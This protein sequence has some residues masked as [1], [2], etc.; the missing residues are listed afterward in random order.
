MEF[1]YIN[2]KLK[3][4]E[5]TYY[6]YCCAGLGDTMI[7]LSIREELEKKFGKKIFFILKKT[8]TVVAK[9]YEEKNCFILE[10][11]EMQAIVEKNLYK[12]PEG[13][14][15]YAAHPAFHEELRDFFRPIYDQNSTE[16]FVPW[17][18]EFFG[19]SGLEGIKEPTYYPP[20]TQALKNKISKFD[21]VDN[22]VMLS[23]EATSMLPMSNRFWESL[24]EELKEKGYTVVSNV[25]RKERTVNGSIYIDLTAE[26]AVILGLN[27]KAVYSVRSGLCDLIFSKGKDLHVYYPTHS[28][29]F[30][31]SLNSMFMRTDI[32]EVILIER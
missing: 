4:D 6:Y 9:M 10:D 16:R 28:S 29:Y 26:E 11:R 21:S 17:F 30:I 14:K 22:I 1:D 31:Y 32:D 25:I 27:C 5:D 7:T 15:I 24:T 18:Y 20:M 8:H 19:L 12:K 13:G 3:L 23:P 2:D